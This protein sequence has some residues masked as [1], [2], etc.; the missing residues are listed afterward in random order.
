MNVTPPVLA[1]DGPSG[2]G[3]G[4][5]SRAIARKL[6]WHFLDSGVLYRSLALA[7]L[8]ASIP[9]EEVEAIAETSKTMLIH[10]TI[11]DPPRILLNGNDVTQD[12]STEICGNMASR[13]A[14]YAPVRRALLDKQHAFR[15]LPGL[16]ADGRDMG[17]VVFPDAVCKIFLTASTEVRAQRRYNQLIEKGV[18]V[19]LSELI[20]DIE[21]RDRRDRE[22]AEAPLVVAD[23][24]IVIDSSSMTVSEVVDKIITN[25]S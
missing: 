19:T 17:T 15:Q 3:K 5:V 25:I 24:A 11:D 4:T 6:G 22:R 21:K 14:A 9:P 16:V 10:F 2:S 13:L 20:Q 7:V 8:S 1:I 23:T 12:I 18:C